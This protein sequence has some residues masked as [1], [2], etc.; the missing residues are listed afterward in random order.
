MWCYVPANDH[1]D[2]YNKTDITVLT[3]VIIIHATEVSSMN[4]TNN[5]TCPKLVFILEAFYGV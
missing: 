2:C 5:S 1:A 3:T 4:R